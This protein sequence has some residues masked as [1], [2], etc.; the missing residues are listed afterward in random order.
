MKPKEFVS[1]LRELRFENVFNPYSDRCTVH[2]V[3]DAPSRRT[4]VLLELLEAA[5]ETEIDAL[6]IGRDLGYRGGRRTGLALT[7]DVHLTIDAVTTV[8]KAVGHSVGDECTADVRWVRA[9]LCNRRPHTGTDGQKRMRGKCD[10][11]PGR[12]VYTV[13]RPMRCLTG[14]DVMRALD[15]LRPAPGRSPRP[16]LHSFPGSNPPQAWPHERCCAE[17]NIPNDEEKMGDDLE[18]EEEV[19]LISALR[20]DEVLPVRKA[21]G[22]V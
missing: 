19:C 1:S 12:D 16:S 6:W 7:D 8:R 17:E 18:E 4:G 22:T 13:Q 14:T 2:D 5:A 9:E 15:S 21:F 10:G 3:S 11:G 20:F